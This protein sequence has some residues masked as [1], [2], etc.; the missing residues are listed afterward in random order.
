MRWWLDAS[1]A[2]RE[3]GFAPR[4]PQETIF[5]TWRWVEARF[6]GR[7]EAAPARVLPTTLPSGRSI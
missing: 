5:E 7:R 4:D 1:K 6:R 3:L 2:R